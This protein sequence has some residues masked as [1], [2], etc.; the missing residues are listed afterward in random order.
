ML[1]LYQRSYN[2]KSEAGAA[3]LLLQYRG[4][5]LFKLVEDSLYIFRTNAYTGIC[6]IKRTGNFIR[7][8]GR[9]DHQLYKTLV[10][11]FDSV[12]Q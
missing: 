6:N 7:I 10:G 3:T 11:K 12:T 8:L 2:G 4:A 1:C 9:F 5:C